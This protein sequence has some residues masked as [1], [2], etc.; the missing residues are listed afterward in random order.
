MLNKFILNLL[1]NQKRSFPDF[2][3]Q[4]DRGQSDALLELVRS[5]IQQNFAKALLLKISNLMIGRYQY[6]NRHDYLISNPYA[7]IIDPANSCP[8][9][10]PGCLH[11][12]EF[13]EKIGP[14]WPSGTLSEKQYT[15]FM[16][17][18]GP[19]ATTALFYNWGEPL[20]NKNTP[21]FIQLAKSFMLETSLS[22]NLS[23]NFD[24]EA[25]VL[26][27]LDYM[28]LSVD[29]ATK[30][31]YNRYRQGG[32]FDL[33]IDNI[34]RL[35]EAKRKY[36]M[37]TPWLS[38]QFLL[39]EHNKHEVDRAKEMAKEL[40]VNEIRF[41]HPYG[42]PW[43]QE[44]T[45]AHQMKEELC[46]LPKDQSYANRFD[47]MGNISTLF[48]DRF[49]EKWA[50]KLQGII[51]GAFSTRTGKTCQ[52]LYTTLVMDAT[53][54]YLPCCYAPRKDSG[55]TFVFGVSPNNERSDPF[56]SE[57]YRFSR[58]HFT[59]RSGLNTSGGVAPRM[60]EGQ[61]ATYCAA[62]QDKHLRPLVNDIHLQRY[63]EINSK[64]SLT[65]ESIRLLSTWTEQ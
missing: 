49:A 53:N 44:L 20:L 14:D 64:K 45:P 58:Q 3:S 48:N 11:N 17:Q 62:C 7:L 35:V 15:Q 22:S 5:G 41:A 30:E 13:Q 8:L 32:Q 40:G 34:R 50:E 4:I 65:Q 6:Q 43:N 37:A 19:Y 27:G 2:L 25:L 38:W 12:K 61:A 10:C 18:F 51:S 29:G 1:G 36:D 59:W 16:K 24:A 63:L 52:W 31:T 26:S 47:I 9:H 28:I 56:N 33:A 57:F 46:K 42:V 21:S 39:F 54:R 55:F 60:A 23:V